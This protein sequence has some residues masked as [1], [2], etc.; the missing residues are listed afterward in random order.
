MSDPISAETITAFQ[1]RL[2]EHPVYEAIVTEA[3]LRCFMEHHIYSV[4]DFMSLVKYLQSVIAPSSYPWVPIGDGSVRRFIN[5]LVMEEESDETFPA[6]AFS[7]HFELYHTAMEEVG[8]DSGPSKVFVEVVRADGIEMALAL[9]TVPPASRAFTSVTFE[10]IHSG[11]AHRVAAGLALGREH[12]IPAMFRGLLSKIGVSDKQAPVFHYYLNRH[13]EL[14]GDSHAPLSL[15]LLRGLCGDD[16]DKEEEA[17]AA[18][19]LAVDARIA[20]W[21]GVLEE[22]NSR[23][24]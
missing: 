11:K 22:I 12:V 8:A 3:D 18:A 14:D 23:N 4:W 10:L 1:N 15:Q 9:P 7:S 20:L 16:K 5:E 13:I 2:N 19:H 24:S 6:G 17:V 21:D